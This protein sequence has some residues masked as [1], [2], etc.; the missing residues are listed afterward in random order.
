MKLAQ[1]RA[2]CTGSV[3]AK[4]HHWTSSKRLVVPGELLELSSKDGFQGKGRSGSEKRKGKALMASMIS[5]L[6]VDQHGQLTT[7]IT[8]RYL[9]VA[10]NAAKTVSYTLHFLPLL[11]LEHID[12]KEP[13]QP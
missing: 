13:S 8:R 6:R 5:L 11:T 10:V 9:L 1:E 2:E 12:T 4:I 3:H 7:R